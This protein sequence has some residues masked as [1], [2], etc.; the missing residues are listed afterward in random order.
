ME[1]TKG[2]KDVTAE[3]LRQIEEEGYHCLH[4]DLN[5][6]GEIARAAL[7]YVVCAFTCQKL[8]VKE[9]QVPPP[10]TNEAYTSLAWPWSFDSWKPG[11]V[12]RMYVKAAALLIAEIDR[13]DRAEEDSERIKEE[14]RND[15]R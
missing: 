11:T 7:N 13:M 2:A 6:P 10:Y 12:R 15:Q 1:P 8:G 5:K 4:D 3:R 14:E 9:T